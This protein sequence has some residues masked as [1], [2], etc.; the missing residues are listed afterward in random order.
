MKA[1]IISTGTELLLG[2][3]VDTN[4]SFLASQLALLGIDLY[5]TSSVGDNYE[6]L[7]GVLRQAWQRSELILMT[8]G[9]GPTQGD[10]TREVIAGLLGERMAVDP[11]L[12][13]NLAKFF[14]ERGLEM[15]PNN[16]KQATLIPSATTLPNPRGTAPGW[17]VE[18][19][20]R[21]IIAMPGP[22]G[23]MQFMWQN[24]VVPKL[25][26][27]AG[28]VIL[29]RTIKTSFLGESRVDELLTDLL[30]S[31]NPTLA[32][33]AKP[34]GIHVRITAKAAQ[35]QEALG[36]ISNREAAVRAILGDYI[37]GADDDTLESVVGQLLV[38]KRLS[39]AVAESFTGGFLTYTLASAPQSHNFFRG[40]LI[41]TS[42]KVKVATGLDPLLVTGRANMEATAMAMASLARCKLDADIGIGIEGCTETVDNVM[43][44][45]AFIAIDAEQAKQPIVRSCSARQYQIVKRAAYYALFD[46]RKLLISTGEKC[47]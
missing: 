6:R 18:K 15:S 2:E 42:N 4:T 7:S 13:E 14:A 1:E 8:G 37:W 22:P 12:K 38:A 36:M 39:L 33:Y 40:G 32:I 29:S 11:G 5:F 20:G 17:W 46:L 21:I 31:S 34:D 43:M 30:S 24:E 23:E 10:I 3:I 35:R 25:Q 28:A 16:V 26:Q 45:K 27:R 41:T 19:D 9:L 47:L 44:G